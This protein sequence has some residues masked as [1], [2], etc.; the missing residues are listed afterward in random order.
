MMMRRLGFLVVAALTL[1]VGSPVVAQEKPG[2]IAQV[3]VTR[4]KPGMG[5]QYQEGRKRHMAWHKQQN[6]PWSW[7]TW[8][9]TTGPGSG[10]YLS[11]SFGHH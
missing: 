10:S 1:A 6:D 8:E 9:V 3:V 2:T 5:K 11:I 7:H 4:V